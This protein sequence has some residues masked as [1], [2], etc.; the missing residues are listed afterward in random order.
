MQLCCSTWAFHVKDSKWL[1]IPVTPRMLDFVY[2][3]LYV[4]EAGE[5]CFFYTRDMMLTRLSLCVEKNKS[6][7]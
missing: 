1:P 6:N 4:Q 3:F 5:A 2:Y 7:S